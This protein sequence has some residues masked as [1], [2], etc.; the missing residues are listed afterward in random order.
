MIECN[1]QNFLKNFEHQHHWTEARKKANPFKAVSHLKSLASDWSKSF[2]IFQ[3]M[4][5][6]YLNDAVMLNN[7]DEWEL[8]NYESKSS[9]WLLGSANQNRDKNPN[10]RCDD[11]KRAGTKNV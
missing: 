7:C 5:K 11:V 8:T 9:D 6:T 10:L 2:L 1:D 3:A 4:E